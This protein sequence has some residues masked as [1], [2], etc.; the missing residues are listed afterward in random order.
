MSALVIDPLKE[1]LLIALRIITIIFLGILQYLLLLL[2]ESFNLK[3]KYSK[4]IR[5]FLCIILPITLIFLG[6]IF[7]ISGIEINV[8]DLPFFWYYVI[9]VMWLGIGIIIYTEERKS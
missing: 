5:L 9:S 7:F 1:N 3:P 6:G 4:A 8:L 2:T